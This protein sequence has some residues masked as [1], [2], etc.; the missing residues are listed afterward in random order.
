MKWRTEIQP[1]ECRGTIDLDTPI[2]TLGS[3]FADEIGNKLQAHSFNVSVN[4]MGIMFN[5]ASIAMAI[6]RALAQVEFNEADVAPTPEGDKYITFHR[7]SKFSATDA[8]ALVKNLNENLAET[9]RL[10]IN[11]KY[12]FLTLGSSRCFIHA[13]QGFPVA[14]CHRYHPKTFV[15]RDLTERD[16]KQLLL[17]V[18]KRLC[19]V[20]PEIKIVITV[21]PVRHVAYGLVADSLSKSRL[22]V[23]S[24]ALVNEI[25]GATYFPAYEALIDDLRDYRF[26][27][28]DLVH[29]S[30]DAVDYIFELFSQSFLTEQLQ[31]RLPAWRNLQRRVS[32]GLLTENQIREAA[33]SLTASETTIN[34]L[35]QCLK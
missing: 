29:P 14:N 23:A 10:L 5:P 9:H 20:N 13:E 27:A 11:A 17:P 26:Y 2:V 35:L 32:S 22:I 21:S 31:S 16:T 4:P 28:R 6:G 18:L 3:C 19:S 25:E 30:E 15:E 7:H 34:R 8:S 12:L 24:H 33:T 1:L